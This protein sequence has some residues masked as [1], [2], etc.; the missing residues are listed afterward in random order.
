M[1]SPAHG[2]RLSD[3]AISCALTDL[4]FDLRWSFNLWEPTHNPRIMRQTISPEK[5]QTVTREPRFQRLLTDLH[6]AE[7]SGVGSPIHL[8]ADSPARRCSG[9]AA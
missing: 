5:L 2:S 3:P 1:S 6:G 9:E 4:A 8:V 7:A